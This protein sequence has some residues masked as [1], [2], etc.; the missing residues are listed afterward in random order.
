[1]Q[2]WDAKLPDQAGQ[3]DLRA[4]VC[5]VQLSRDK[6]HMLAVGC[7]DHLVHLYDLRNLGQPLHAF[8]GALQLHPKISQVQK[9]MGCE[10]RMSA[11][12]TCVMSARA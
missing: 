5:S 9:Q 7:A 3:L 6:E 8:A 12:A 11:A 1:M 10:R 2:V 4:N